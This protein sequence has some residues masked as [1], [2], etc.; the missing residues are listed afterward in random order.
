MQPSSLSFSCQS[1]FSCVCTEKNSKNAYNN[2]VRLVRAAVEG[3]W[4]E[5][6][7]LISRNFDLNNAYRS[8]T[9]LMIAASEGKIDVITKSLKRHVDIY[10]KDS[11]GLTALTYAAR[12]NQTK[13]IEMILNADA[14]DVTTEPLI[15]LADLQDATP[16]IHAVRKGHSAAIELLLK[17]GADLDIC[18]KDGMSVCLIAIWENKMEAL[19]T[20]LHAGACFNEK[21]IRLPSDISRIMPALMQEGTIIDFKKEISELVL[22]QLSWDTT[23][24]VM[25]YFLI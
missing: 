3:K 5:V 16:L 9:I 22:L 13:A 18:A 20:L 7:R 12:A 23:S 1:V 25:E 19:K 8:Q 17:R 15:D 14:L 6:D 11:Y 2:H 4:K 21:E 24:V 10:Q